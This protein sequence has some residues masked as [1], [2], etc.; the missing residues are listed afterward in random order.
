VLAES[1][2]RKPLQDKVRSAWKSLTRSLD[3]ALW[4]DS[5]ICKRNTPSGCSSRNTGRAQTRRDDRRSHRGCLGAAAIARLLKSDRLIVWVAFHDAV[6]AGGDQ[7]K[8]ADAYKEVLKGD[9]Q[10][11]EATTT[12]PSVVTTAA[13]TKPAS[14]EVRGMALCGGKGIRTALLRRQAPPVRKG[15]IRVRPGVAAVAAPS[16]V[17]GQNRVVEKTIGMQSFAHHRLFLAVATATLGLVL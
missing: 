11:A 1:L 7:K 14:N 8:L 15:Q 10:A 6:A 9:R 13:G 3:P 17:T 12:R 16:E 2:S 5:T 4:A